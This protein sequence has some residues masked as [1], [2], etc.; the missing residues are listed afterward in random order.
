M[1]RVKKPARTRIYTKTGDGGETSLFGGARVGKDAIR[2]EAYG[3]VDELNSS[4]GYCRSLKLPAAVDRVLGA[5]QDDLFL[6]GAILASPGGGVGR[7]EQADVERLEKAIDRF[8]AA[9]PPLRNFILP[10][11]HPSAAMLHVARTVCRRA[12]RLVVRAARSERIDPL[13]IVYLNR[14]SDLLFILARTTNRRR[15]QNEVRWTRR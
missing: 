11:G 2:I 3:T 8:D 1:T 9:L 10:G 4:L 5:I 14:L 7:I 13:V 6:L 15:K 12:E